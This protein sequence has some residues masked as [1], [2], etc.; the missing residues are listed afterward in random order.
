MKRKIALSAKI[1]QTIVAE[2][3]LDE[4]PGS[5]S[6]VFAPN[7]L[8]QGSIGA[9][10][11][12][13]LNSPPT[14]QLMWKYRSFN[15][16]LNQQNELHLASLELTPL[17]LDDQVERQPNFVVRYSAS[18][19]SA[20]TPPLNSISS[21]IG[22]APAALPS[23][24]SIVSAAS[25]SSSHS[26]TTLQKGGLLGAHLTLTRNQWHKFEGKAVRP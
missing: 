5:Y 20:E 11:S 2:V 21:L 8:K 23:A 9:I 3:E 26:S 19:S 16:L 13:D 6:L 17:E 4:I 18:Q 1:N 25:S 22:Q 24:Q 7:D 15:L 14:I 12:V 10:A